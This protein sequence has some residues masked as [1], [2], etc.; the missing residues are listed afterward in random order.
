MKES[1]PVFIGSPRWT[2]PEHFEKSDMAGIKGDI[3]SFGVILWELVTKQVPWNQMHITSEISHAV[4]AGK[5]LE[6]PKN[7]PSAIKKILNDCWKQS[8]KK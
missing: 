1:D 2:S 8:K 4:T 7:C 6:I 5:R 3:Y